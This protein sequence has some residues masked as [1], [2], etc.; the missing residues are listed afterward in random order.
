[1]GESHG[2]N[3]REEK[4]IMPLSSY[5]KVRDIIKK[6][7]TGYYR[8][9][10]LFPREIRHA[11]WI[12]YTFVRL[13]DEIVD[14]ASVS[15]RTAKLATWIEK[16]NTY[17]EHRGITDVEVFRSFAEVMDE[18]AI[19]AEYAASFLEVM[20]QDL[21]V[22]RYETYRDLEGYMYGAAVVVGY[23]MSHIVGFNDGAL[24]HAKA[25]GEAFQM[26][27]FLRDI[28]EDYEERGRIYIPREDMERFGV[29]ERHIADHHTDDAW[30]ALMKFE[31]D[32]TR[33]LYEK[34]VSGIPLLDPRGRRAVYA[35]ALLYKEILNK[36][37][38]RGYDIFTERVVVSP[39]RKTMLLLQALWKRKL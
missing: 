10:F 4:I 5:K 31:I 35:A 26:T 3:P 16:W 23:T 20:R 1:M 27:N 18:Y 13:P 21:S 22:T 37:E 25:L 24:P 17:L 8:A 7:G 2:T 11:T 32:R 14:G 29:S 30:R 19:P 6:Y 28:R 38:N 36:I 39:L 33:A 34:G 15:D 12:Y 9:T